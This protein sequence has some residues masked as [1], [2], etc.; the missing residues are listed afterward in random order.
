MTQL[1]CGERLDGDLQKNIFYGYVYGGCLQITTVHF[2][3]VHGKH[4]CIY[5]DYLHTATK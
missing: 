4:S 2:F 3:Y 5:Q 1:I